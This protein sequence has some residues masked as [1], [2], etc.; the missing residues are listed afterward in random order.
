MAL[1]AGSLFLLQGVVQSGSIVWSMKSVATLLISPNQGRVQTSRQWKRRSNEIENYFTNQVYGQIDFKPD[2][3][4]VLVEEPPTPVFGG[5]ARRCQLELVWFHQG[6]EKSVRLLCYMPVG[7]DSVPVILAGNNLGNHTVTDNVNIQLP[8]SWVP[9]YPYL[10]I[11]H[12]QVTEQSRGVAS[13]QWPIASVIDAGF[14]LVTFYFGDIA[15]DHRPAGLHS[16]NSFWNDTSPGGSPQHG[17]IAEWSW[18]ISRIMDT[19]E[20]DSL[21]DRRQVF[22]AGEGGLGKAICRTVALDRRFAGCWIRESSDIGGT[23][24]PSGTDSLSRQLFIQRAYWFK[25]S[26]YKQYAFDLSF[27]FDELY[28]LTVACPVPVY[29][30][31]LYSEGQVMRYTSSVQNK[32]TRL[33]RFYE[34]GH[35][36]KQKNSPADSSGIFHFRPIEQDKSPKMQWS[37]FLNF[38]KALIKHKGY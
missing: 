19:L 38:A 9:N 10:G 26:F 33:Y 2:S 21:V 12:H 15:G 30:S 11:E 16:G 34:Q 31:P 4:S 23:F 25:P 5:K 6:K 8:E 22:L 1:V 24:T 29:F 36:T 28:L 18:G 32:F 20:K 13:D 27:P 3:S 7:K 35:R 14:G 37:G 17:R